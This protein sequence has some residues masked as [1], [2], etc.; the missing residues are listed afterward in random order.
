MDK[1]F[2]EKLV[3]ALLRNGDAI[4]FEGATGLNAEIRQ[5][6][7]EIG[8]CLNLA[9]GRD[10]ELVLTLGHEKEGT[11]AAAKQSLFAA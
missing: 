6:L 8:A 9:A 3:A 7:D 1:K 11:C 10:G 5:S 2:D 4:D